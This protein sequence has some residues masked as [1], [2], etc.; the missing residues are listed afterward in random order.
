MGNG[1]LLQAVDA[2]KLRN[3]PHRFVHRIHQRGWPIGGQY[4]Q[5]GPGQ[6][7]YPFDYGYAAKLIGIYLN[8]GGINNIIQMI[9]IDADSGSGA[10]GYPF[11]ASGWL[12]SS[13]TRSG[14]YRAVLLGIFT[15]RRRQRN[16]L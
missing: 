15:V 3:F 4:A 7:V 14:W 11:P 2:I 8:A 10:D 9:D 6:A 1:G 12:F 5:S 13:L 16:T